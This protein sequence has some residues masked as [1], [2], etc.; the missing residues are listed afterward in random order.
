MGFAAS[1]EYIPTLLSLGITPST[2]LRLQVLL[3]DI[4]T[5]GPLTGRHPNPAYVPPTAFHT[6]S[7]VCSR[8][9]LAS[10]FHPAAVS[11]VPSAGVFPNNQRARLIT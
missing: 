3:H 6:L 9:L 2:S 8:L 10:L 11:K 5:S 4:T 7:V 1:S